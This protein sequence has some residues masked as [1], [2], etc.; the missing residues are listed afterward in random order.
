[1]R[2]LFNFLLLLGVN[3]LFYLVVYTI[4]ESLMNT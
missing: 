2:I 3:I 1:M 4:A